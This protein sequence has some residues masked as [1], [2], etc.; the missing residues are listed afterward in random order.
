MRR[1][2]YV[3]FVVSVLFPAWSQAGSILRIP[4][5]WSA[6]VVPPDPYTVF[7]CHFDGTNGQTTFTDVATGGSAPHAITVYG[8]AQVSTTSPKW[9]TGSLLLDGDSDFLTADDSADWAF[10]SGDF[11]IELWVRLD[12]VDVG[13]KFVSQY[14][15]STSDMMDFGYDYSYGLRVNVVSGGDYVIWLREANEVAW[16]ADTWYHVALV[17]YGDVWTIYRSGVHQA[18]NGQKT[19]SSAYPD[20]SGYLMIGRKASGDEYVDG[21]IDDLRIVKGV[22]KYTAD[23]TPPNAPFNP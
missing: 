8:T 9:G 4:R 2:L 12:R 10:G 3:L 20:Y 15:G 17:R 7:L 22:A 6:G 19:V 16:N 23:F 21:R 18:A 1:L 5:A 11:T 14:S 13:Q